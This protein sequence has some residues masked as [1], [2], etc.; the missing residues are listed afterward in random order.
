MRP[1]Q[2]EISRLRNSNVGQRRNLVC[3]LISRRIAQQRVEFSTV[4]P[5]E[6][7][8]DFEILEFQ[9]LRVQHLDI[10]LDFF[11]GTIIHQTVGLNLRRGQIRGHVH[12]DVCHTQLLGRPQAHV[13]DDDHAV[14]IDHDAL[15]KSELLDGCSDLVDCGLRD[16]PRV[17]GVFDWLVNGP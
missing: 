11:V 15:P 10:P 4:E 16:P 13:A 5:G 17:A 12:G 2:P 1:Q 7:H 8:V 9:Q 6:N 3:L 14:F